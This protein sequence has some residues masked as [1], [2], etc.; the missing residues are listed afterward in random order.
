MAEKQSI[1]KNIYTLV[2]DDSG[3]ERSCANIPD[4]ACEDVPT[5]FVRNALSG[6]FSKIRI[7][8]DHT[9]TGNGS[10]WGTHE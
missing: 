7:R 9:S 1:N 8:I 4:E 10:W 6:V 3:E 2:T 5:G